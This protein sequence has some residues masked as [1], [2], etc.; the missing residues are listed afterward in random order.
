MN[1]SRTYSQGPTLP[2]PDSR[3]A[4][5]LSQKIVSVLGRSFRWKWPT[6]HMSS[7]PGKMWLLRQRNPLL[8]QLPNISTNYNKLPYL[9][10]LDLSGHVGT[11]RNDFFFKHRYVCHLQMYICTSQLKT[12]SFLMIA[13][14]STHP[15]P[16]S[17]SCKSS[18]GRSCKDLGFFAWKYSKKVDTFP[19]PIIEVVKGSL[20]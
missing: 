12:P 15:G 5:N 4:G 17:K 8:Q 3:V 14:I 7:L 19:P 2:K 18:D 6:H 1:T 13:T 10:K 20:T 9:L 11:G 16:G